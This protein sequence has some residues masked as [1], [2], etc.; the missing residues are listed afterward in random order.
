[1]LLVLQLGL[2]L[3]MQ[4]AKESSAIPSNLWG[5]SMSTSAA[6]GSDVPPQPARV[7]EQE[8]PQRQ[9]LPGQQAQLGTSPGHQHQPQ[10]QQ[11][12]Q[13]SG[14]TCPLCLS[15]RRHPTSTPCGHVF[16][17]ACVAQWCTEKPECPLC[18]TQVQLSQLVP[19]YHSTLF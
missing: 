11:Q 19:V 18:R 12:P 3:L 15:Q 16:C 9:L 17:W 5:G 1:M 7:L 13:G 6:S 2:V 8:E 14:G 4:A 10:Q